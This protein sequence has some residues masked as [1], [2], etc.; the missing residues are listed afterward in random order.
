MKLLKDILY[1]AGLAEVIGST[2][3]AITSI[4]FDSRKVEKNALFIAVKGLTNDGHQYIDNT[5]VAGAVAIVCEEFPSKINEKITYIKV[6]NSSFSLGVIAANFYD[7]PSEKI[8]LIGITGTNGKTTTATLLFHLFRGLG[9]NVG[10]LS[11]VKNQINNEIFPALHTTPDAIDLNKLLNQMLEK[12]CT[13]CF[14]E[15][16]SHAIVQNRIAGIHFTGAVFT[17]IS[18]DHLDYHKTFAEYIKAKKLFFDMLSSD[19][20]A[21]VNKDDANGEVMLQNTKAQKK[22]FS[23]RSMADFKCK[24]IENQF[25]GLTLN[26][27]GYEVVTKL[28]GTFNAYNLLGIYAVAMLLKEEKINTLTAI[29]TLNSVEGRFQYISTENKI[30][31]IVDYAHTPD[32][33]LNV[34]KTIKDIRTGNENVITVVGCGGNR[35]AE[36]R[37]IMAGIACELSDKVIL[38]SD[39]PRS[40]N[41]EEIIRQMQKGVEGIYY[42]KT[43]SISDRREAI[44]T[45]CSFAKPGDIILVAGKGHE[46]YQEINGEKFPFD[47]LKVLEENLKIFEK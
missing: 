10:L 34:L 21:L 6:A 2:N 16:S 3:V 9:Y 27:D 37:P 4:C 1:K 8:K 7:N 28:I 24:I 39:N 44:K 36:K 33:L 17:N 11:T 19:A 18:H 43:V 40:E 46:K 13:H 5:I 30:I 29:S 38:T 25:S 22:T 20:F 12:G 47:D 41:P 26:I 14:M 35:D 42:K 32:A 45:A 23:L 31:G 15:V